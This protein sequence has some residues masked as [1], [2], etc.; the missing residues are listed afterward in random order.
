MTEERLKELRLRKQGGATYEEIG[1]EL[2]C[3]ASKARRLLKPGARDEENERR[4]IARVSR[5]SK[6]IK[7]ESVTDVPLPIEQLVHVENY[8]HRDL[9]GRI[10]GDPRVGF[11]ALDRIKPTKLARLVA[12]RSELRG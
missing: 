10:L 7:T 11:S 9:T 3:S 1:R 2:G 6:I 4:R 12:L 8:P 5:S